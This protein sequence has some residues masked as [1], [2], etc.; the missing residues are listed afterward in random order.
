MTLCNHAIVMKAVDNE[1][2]GCHYN[3][4]MDPM[5]KEVQFDPIVCV[6][7]FSITLGT[8]EPYKA[9]CLKLGALKIF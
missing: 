6:G 2:A 4:L 7:W 9:K 8:A 3:P 1:I 5:R